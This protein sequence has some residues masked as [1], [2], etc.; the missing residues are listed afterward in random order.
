MI[1]VDQIDTTHKEMQQIREMTRI[2]EQQTW[3]YVGMKTHL[4]YFILL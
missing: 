3:K 2:L 4:I 1:L